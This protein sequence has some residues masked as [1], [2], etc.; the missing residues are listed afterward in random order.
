MVSAVLPRF[1]SVL[2]VI[3]K[4]LGCLNIHLYNGILL[5]TTVPMQA[6]KC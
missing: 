2:K 1:N 6:C 5:F 3:C 4:I